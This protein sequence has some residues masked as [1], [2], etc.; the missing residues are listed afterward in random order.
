MNKKE[1]LLLAIGEGIKPIQLQI[2][3][4]LIKGS[5]NKRF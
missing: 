3:L 5:D 1:Q 2:L 4:F